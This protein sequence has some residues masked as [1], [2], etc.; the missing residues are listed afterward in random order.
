MQV[1]CTALFIKNIKDNINL[2]SEKF[3]LKID[4]I[5]IEQNGKTEKYFCVF[6]GGLHLALY[7][8]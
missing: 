7:V 1:S 2:L 6:C 5:F 4:S 8:C 3:S